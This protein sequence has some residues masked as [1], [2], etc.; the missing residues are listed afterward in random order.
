MQL[1]LNTLAYG[2]WS[3]TQ[4]PVQHRITALYYLI[5]GNDVGRRALNSYI[6]TDEGF[7]A[8]NATL[9]PSDFGF[10]LYTITSQQFDG[11]QLNGL[12]DYFQS[13]NMAGAAAYGWQSGSQVAQIFN[14]PLADSVYAEVNAFLNPQ[15]SHIRSKGYGQ[16]S[17]HMEHRANMASQRA[18]R[19]RR[20]Q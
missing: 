8:F 12:V 4:L 5:L 1:W 13:Q 16:G 20:V 10:V 7:G 2:T 19:A 11:T 14:L 9:A 15:R 3:D 18:E 17:A 6:T